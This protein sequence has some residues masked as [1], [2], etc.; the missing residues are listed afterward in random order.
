MIPSLEALITSRDGFALVTASPL[1]RAVCRIIEGRPLGELAEREDVV[2]ALGGAE[3]I[4]ALPNVPPGEVVILSGIRTFK[5]GLAAA[6]AIRAS[7]VCDTRGLGPGEVPRVSVVSLTLDLSR[8]VFGHIVGQVQERPALRRLLLEDPT[9]DSVILRHPT[10]RPV[11]IKCVAGARA[12][13][14]LVARW[15]AG[16][17]FDEAP[18]MVGIEDGVV[19][20]DDAR[21]AVLGRLLP[22]AQLVS[23]GSPWAPA[24]PIY[25]AFTESFGRPSPARVVIR[26]T[27][28]AMNPIWWTPARCEQLRATDPV[29]YETD[30]L[31]RFAAAEMS[32]LPGSAI[33]SAFA[34]HPDLDSI[35]EPYLFADWSQ[36]RHDRIAMLV[37]AWVAPLVA[38][39]EDQ[40]L[41][42]PATVPAGTEVVPGGRVGGMVVAN[43]HGCVHPVLDAN[44]QQLP[45][46]AFDARPIF[47]VFDV[48]SWGK[49]ERD[50]VDA[51]TIVREGARLAR[52]YGARKAFGDQFEAWSLE[53]IFKR[54]DLR[55]ATLPWTANAKTGAFDHLRT[56]L[57][58]GQLSLPPHAT[59]LRE[60]LHRVRSRPTVRGGFEYV[61]PG[62]SGH[63]D[64]LSALLL[65]ARADADRLLSSSPYA[66]S[67]RKFVL[68]DYDDSGEDAA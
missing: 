23:V 19:N 29:A 45:N 38:H 61:V 8:V 13:A 22:G 41:W 11:E 35:G 15:S 9:S 39:P 65:A 3:A 4:A 55:F 56:L 62:A 33:E 28:P 37:A 40:W 14:S 31:G 43:R 60:E 46:D 32:T 59:H 18:R 10:G 26:G 27:G 53:S 57:V 68:N 21:R 58:G 51:E 54:Y 30:V 25:D 1:Q 24:G 50:R 36:L 47:K 63:G 12:G 64:H 17:V 2:D 34:N 7:Q 42:V 44:G 49:H 66:R 52:R 6:N 16:V 20:Y 48:V 5:S 67:R